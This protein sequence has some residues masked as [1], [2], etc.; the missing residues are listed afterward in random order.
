MNKWVK[1]T[2][3]RL[4]KASPTIDEYDEVLRAA[5]ERRDIV[6]KYDKG[7]EEGAQIDPWEDPAFEVYHVL[8]R[9]GFIHDHRLP[10]GR[11]A[12][13]SKAIEIERERSK[14]WLKM[15]NKWEQYYPGEKIVRRIYKGIP[16]GLRGLVWARILNINKT[17]EEQNG[18]YKAMR[19]RARKKSPH[20]RQ[21]DIDVNRTYR[22]HIM[23]RE[24]YGVK[25]QALFHV[26]AA[27]STYNTEVG[28]CQ[29]MSE[30]AA[31]LLM[32]LNE[33]DAFWGLSQLFCSKQHGMHGFFIPGFPKLFRYQ[34]HH[35]VILKK[36]LPKVRKYFE[37]NDIYPSLYSIKWF[38]QC[39]LGRIPFT[40]TLRLW[41]IYILEG[42]K[43]LS[44]MAYNIIKLHRRK[45]MRM[46][47]D[48]ILQFFQT[49]LEKNFGY[50]DDTV[51]DQLQIC[52]EELRK[53]KMDLP[54]RPKVNEE[55]TLPFGLEIEPS[56]EQIIKGRHPETIDEHFKRNPH[57]GKA[58]YL[59]KRGLNSVATPDMPRSRT[60]SSRLSEYSMD[61][62][63]TY[64]DTA[65]N[66]RIS[67]S[68]TS[69]QSSR[70]SYADDSDVEGFRQTPMMDDLDEHLVGMENGHPSRDTT[71]E[72]IAEEL[73]TPS[74]HSDY[75][76]IENSASLNASSKA[77]FHDAMETT[78]TE[79]PVHHEVSIHIPSSKSDGYIKSRSRMENGEN[80][81][82]S[83]ASHDIKMQEN[84]SY[85]QGAKS[86]ND[87]SSSPTRYV[88]KV[89]VHTDYNGHPNGFTEEH[90][91][92][93]N[94]HN[95]SK[96][97]V[98]ATNFNQRLVSKH[99]I[100][101]KTS[102]L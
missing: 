51:I 9:W 89:N 100:Q 32:Y 57:K 54:P 5:E 45:M 23:F 37:R 6:A 4:S 2:M 43:V 38:L 25:Q 18:V 11:D 87:I 62:T 8:D 92:P 21:I 34:E 58:G 68:K 26:L 56:I 93:R 85:R 64:Y 82:S 53:A 83:N 76:N 69:M 90:M 40:L 41:D 73:K 74:V 75:D 30:I 10:E 31:L 81:N 84:S 55:P 65:A 77:S 99:Q 47:P 86:A 22:N 24:R 3:C 61:D 48:E 20:I 28:Y 44:A 50:D 98:S 7:R 78:I 80:H 14:K 17:R 1:R 46:G 63:S 39:F 60:D 12:A 70:T 72:N 94:M 19:D 15:I 49:E 102:Q 52:M 79:V 101:L 13:E 66:S 42:E 29:G 95:S 96:I 36:F 16:A 33:E 97:K 88:S 59:K 27:Y 67:F 91:S 71:I 35:D